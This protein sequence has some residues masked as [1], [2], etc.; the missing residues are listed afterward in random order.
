MP[1]TFARKFSAAALAGAA[2]LALGACASIPGANVAPGSP[3]TAEE[4]QVGAQYHE[5]F[6]AEF[7]GEMTGPYARYVEQVGSNIALQSGLASRPDA[8]EVTLLNSSVNNAFAVP[9]GYVYATRQLVNLMNNE[10]E[11]AAVLGHEVGHVAARHSARRQQAAQRNQ[12]LGLLGTIIGG[13]VLGSPELAQLSQQGAQALTLSYSRSQ[14]LEAD[15]LGVQYLNRAGYDPN[16]MATL[17]ASLAAQNQLDAQLQGRQ[18][19]TIPE[20]ASTHP[21]PASRV[22][23]AQQ[24]A[25]G[26]TGRLN[27]ETFLQRIDGMIYG[28]DPE[29]GV[30]E[31]RQFIHP[32]LRFTFTAPQG[33]YMVNGTRAVSING[34]SGRA[35]LT[36][37]QYNGDLGAYVQNVFNAIG[38]DQQQIRPQSIQRT[39]VN[40]LPAAYGT[41]RVNNGQ[42]QVDV[43]VFAYEFANDRAYHFQAITPAG[44]AG[45]FNSLYQSFRPISA[46]EAGSV[47]PRRIDIV[48]AGRSDTVATMARRMAYDNGQEARFRVLNGLGSGDRVVPGQQYKIVVRSN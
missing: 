37:G 28:D 16:A 34:D 15:Q 3:I 4:Q 26:G 39:T 17:L 14:E 19:A 35:Q 46:A 5:Q 30:I 25:A 45:N 1:R 42:Q 38:G 27:R 2:S 36:L 7:G 31:G 13:A 44:Q 22:R 20:W 23:N 32:I 21:D 9:G 48:T 12:L 47:V 10:A 41:A 6:V 33:T 43:T 24:L 29:Q 40:G 11:L 8:F 18:N